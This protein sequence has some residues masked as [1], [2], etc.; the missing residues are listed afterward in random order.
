MAG[1]SQ[2]A[3]G[4]REGAHTDTARH[5]FGFGRCRDMFRNEYS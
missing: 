3:H 2:D 1:P 4:Q 5:P